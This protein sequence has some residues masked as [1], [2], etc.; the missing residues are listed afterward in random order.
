MPRTPK[1]DPQLAESVDEARNALSAV[2]P[3]DTV[4]GEHLGVAAEADRMVTHRFAAQ[5]H[6]YQG[7]DW[8]VTLGRASRSKVV[9]VCDSGLVPG[10]KAL[11]APEWVPWS[12][13]MAPEEIAAAKAVADGAHPQK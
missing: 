13:R 7:W 11:L 2:V 5:E 3:A 6:G 12:E 10:E 4:I 1:L 9:T 8:F